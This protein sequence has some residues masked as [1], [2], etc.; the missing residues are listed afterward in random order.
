MTEGKA[1]ESMTPSLS[2][3]L[4][5]ACSQPLIFGRYDIL[6]AYIGLDEEKIL[7]YQQNHICKCLYIVVKRE[8]KFI[9]A[10]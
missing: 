2:I 9:L 5:I 1:N 10:L 6:A 4:S 8:M 3:Y 7:N